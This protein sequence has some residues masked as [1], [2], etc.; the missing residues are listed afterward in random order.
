MSIFFTLYLLLQNKKEKLIKKTNYLCSK[1]IYENKLKIG[2]S[3]GEIW[4]NATSKQKYQI[5]ILIYKLERKFKI[6]YEYWKE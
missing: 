5:S 3:L 6:N 2:C 1:I 4:E